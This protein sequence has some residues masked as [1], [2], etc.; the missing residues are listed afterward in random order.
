LIDFDRAAA[1]LDEW[2]AWFWGPAPRSRRSPAAW[3]AAIGAPVGYDPLAPRSDALPTARVP[4]SERDA[5]NAAKREPAIG[6]IVGDP[7]QTGVD[8]R[9]KYEGP[10]E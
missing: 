2:A 6:R 4:L 1:T 10:D 9:M 3:R 7:G 5:V 8:R